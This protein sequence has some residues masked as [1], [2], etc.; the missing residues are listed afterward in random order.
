[1]S[2]DQSGS[3]SRAHS[4]RISTAATAKRAR[5]RQSMLIPRCAGETASGRSNRTRSSGEAPVDWC[6][7]RRRASATPVVTSHSSTGCPSTETRTCCSRTE[8]D[9]YALALNTKSMTS[10]T[11]FE[12][13]TANSATD[14]AVQTPISSGVDHPLTS[15]AR[16]R[17]VTRGLCCPTPAP[18][19][20][21]GHASASSRAGRRG[22]GYR[23]PAR[24]SILR[25]AM[26]DTRIV[27]TAYRYRRT[28]V[29]G[30]AIAVA[31]CS[32]VETYNRTDR[33]TGQAFASRGDVMLR[34]DKRDDLAGAS[35]N[36]A[37]WEPI[38][39]DR[40]CFGVQTWT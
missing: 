33:A 6:T 29:F 10:G 31:S 8:E 26:T 11:G 2:L 15:A 20:R 14:A 5:E 4:T 23:P 1:M 13:R 28:L 40:R 17:A 32:P 16:S 37:T 30:V 19:R 22:A 9:T 38:R 36:C 25:A 24:C 12:N 35:P 21:G 34:V 27:T 7:L 39:P 3:M 18:L